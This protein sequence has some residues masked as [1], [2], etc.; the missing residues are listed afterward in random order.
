MKHTLLVRGKFQK[1]DANS[2]SITGA[3]PSVMHLKKIGE[4]RSILP[5]GVHCL[6][7]T[8]TATKSL[9]RKVSGVVGLRNPKI[10]A[11]SPAR[12]TLCT[13]CPSF[14]LSRIETFKPLL[15]CIR[16]LRLSMPRVIIYCRMV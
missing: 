2:T 10:I 16:K 8:A 3:K 4:V 12:G 14:R 1:L 11:V 7:F 13:E 9:R 15:E 5:K 6:C